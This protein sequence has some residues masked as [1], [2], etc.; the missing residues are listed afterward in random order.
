MHQNHCQTL[1]TAAIQHATQ[2]GISV[3]ISVYDPGANLLS[4]QK[5]EG[6]PLGSIDIAMNKAR[7][8]VLFG[9]P[10]EA[11]GE[12]ARNQQLTG[13]EQTNN[14]LILFAGGEPIRHNNTVIGGIGISG[15]SAEQDKEIALFAIEQLSIKAVQEAS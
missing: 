2:L 14:G 13:F 6:A 15:G 3:N 5:M 8:A 11:L 10:T 9:A 12:L 1:T 4:F 7:S